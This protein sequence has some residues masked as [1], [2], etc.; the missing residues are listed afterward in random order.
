MKLTFQLRTF[1]SRPYTQKVVP[2]IATEKEMN[3]VTR[4]QSLELQS[5]FKFSKS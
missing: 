2:S 1:L 4:H 3:I 5:D